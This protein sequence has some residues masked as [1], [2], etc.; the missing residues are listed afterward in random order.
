M[1]L[2]SYDD[3]ITL[4]FLIEPGDLLTAVSKRKTKIDNKVEVKFVKMGISV[5]G[6][7]YRET[8]CLAKGEIMFS[9]DEN[10]PLHKHQVIKLG[11]RRRILV[12][13]SRILNAQI[14][15]LSL[16]SKEK[17]ILLIAYDIDT[18]KAYLVSSLAKKLILEKSLP[19]SAEE[20]ISEVRKYITELHARFPELQVVI[21]GNPIMNRE[22]SDIPARFFN[23]PDADSA[24]KFL[25]KLGILQK[26][27]TS[28]L[29]RQQE[30]I[31][32]FIQGIGKNWVHGKEIYANLDRVRKAIVTQRG[33][34]EQK[35]LVEQIDK[36]AEVNFA[37]GEGT[38]VIDAFGG[39]V[40]EIV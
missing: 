2:D 6:V 33:F 16:A 39:I 19:S 11:L 30:L 12:E 23:A 31:D 3:F 7:E 13:K 17:R 40:A 8:D 28:L 29:S 4:P 9:S 1:L 15:L 32:E 35:E 38:E 21:V 36:F 27:L 25:V 22:L 14:N 20:A 37:I 34:A 18:I 26:L 5:K 24:I 10:V